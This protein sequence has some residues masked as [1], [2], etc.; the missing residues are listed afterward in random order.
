MKNTITED[1]VDEKGEKSQL[2]IT[3]SSEHAIKLA[4]NY[5][6]QKPESNNKYMQK[7]AKGKGTFTSDIGIK[8]KGFVPIF[9]L[10]VIIALG[11]L[12]IAYIICRT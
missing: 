5:K 1:F 4:A 6:L 9:T 3:P 10:A 11:T 12:V 2:I 7:G 8:S